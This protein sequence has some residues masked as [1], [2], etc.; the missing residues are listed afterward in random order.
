M[1][2]PDEIVRAAEDALDALQ[3]MTEPGTIK[4]L[5]FKWKK[6]DPAANA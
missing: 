4:E 3:T 2:G 5:P 1:L 6:P